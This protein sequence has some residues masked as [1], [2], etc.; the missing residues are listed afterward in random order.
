MNHRQRIL[1][2]MSGGVDS[3]AA[4]MLLQEQGY[5]VIGLT[6]RMWDVQ[7]QFSAT[8]Q[9]EPDYILEAR[10]LADRLG[11]EHHTLDLRT[12][13][14]SHIIQP[15]L[16]EYLQGRTPNPCVLCNHFFKWKYLIEEA[17]RL[18]CD[19]IATGHYARII[20][21]NGKS[22][23][24]CGIDKQKDQ[25]YFLWRLS[26]EQ[27]TRTLFPLGEW[28]KT[29]LKEY[30]SR[31]GFAQKARKKESMEICF[32]PED[33]RDLLQ[34]MIPDL[35]TRIGSGFFVDAKG[36][37]IGKHRGYPFYTIG[38]RKGLGTAL[39]YP[40]Y[41]IRI[42][43]AKNTIRLGTSDELRQSVALISDTHINDRFLSSKNLS[44]RIRYRSQAIP[45]TVTLATD[46]HA[47]IHF[48]E[49]ASALTP[50]QSAVIYDNDTVVGGG[51]IEDN[52]LL[53]KYNMPI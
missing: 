17:D 20:N 52:R 3:S 23:L 22:M 29:E 35:D 39:G 27:L 51:I 49:K 5:E 41:V 7:Y 30:V 53:K 47:I 9:T 34:E 24:A 26:E 14:R 4:C 28:E 48:S 10:E 12:L 44:V 13:F 18:H 25:S 33:Y 19:K 6:L 42:N 40:A 46:S 31:K 37:K 11:I 1:V 32:V 38:Q 43:A 36:R 45:A 8:G 21:R 50:G 15:F 16:D 2:G